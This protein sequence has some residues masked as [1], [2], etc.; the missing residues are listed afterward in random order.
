MA[1]AYSQLTVIVLPGTLTGGQAARWLADAG[2]SAL[3][4]RR[5]GTAA[6]DPCARLEATIPGACS[7]GTTALPALT[8]IVQVPPHFHW[9][10]GVCPGVVLARMRAWPR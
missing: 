1:C 2:A 5:A 8:T 3:F 7:V 4:V 6:D 10:P 9:E